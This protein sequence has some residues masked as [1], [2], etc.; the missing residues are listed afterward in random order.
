M[1]VLATDRR[2]QRQDARRVLIAGLVAWLGFIV[3]PCVMA[4]PLAKTAG[5]VDVDLSS[6]THHGSRVP[7]DECLHCVDIGSTRAPAMDACDDV[8]IASASPATN[9]LD[10][11]ESNWTPVLTYSILPDVQR[12][13]ARFAGMFATEHL[14]RT[15]SL[16]VAYCVYLE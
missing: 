7:A 14:P 3:Q 8:S 5:N 13:I 9:P 11:V 2:N 1:N 16:T 15:V 12:A 10:D 4:A 6:V